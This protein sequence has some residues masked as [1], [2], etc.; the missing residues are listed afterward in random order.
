MEP[1][2]LILIAIT[3]LVS[4]LAFSNQGLFERYKFNVSSILQG[5]QWDRMISSGFLHVDPMHLLFNMITLYFFA[6][7]VIREFTPLWFVLIYFGS[8]VGGSLLG[9]FMHKD[10]AYYS[11]VGASGAVSGIIFAS[12]VIYPNAIKI[13]GIIPGWIFAIVYLFYSIY[14]MKN[15][16]GN[17]GHSAHL[18]GAVVGFVAPLLLSPSLFDR[19]QT[20]ILLMLVPIIFLFVQMFREK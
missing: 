1:I 18:G 2:T 15:Q 13:Y 19:N 20:Y 9:L 3:S 8:L 11:A 16:V 6:D 17:I 4:Y 14:G 12:I 10:K 7:V 5:K